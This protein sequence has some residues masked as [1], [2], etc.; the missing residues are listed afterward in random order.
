MPLYSQSIKNF[1]SGISQQA[2]IQR[3][4]EQ[5]EVQSNGLSTESAGLQKRPPTIFISRLMDA[6]PDNVQPL[7]HFIDRDANEKYIVY[8]FNNTIRIFDFEGNEKAVNMQ[9]DADYISTDNPKDELRLVTIADY[10]FIVNTN[11][12]VTMSTTKSPDSFSTQGALINVK[13]GQYGRTYKIW[14]DGQEVASHTTPD[15]SDK[16]H[17]AMIDTH[18]IAEQLAARAREAGKTVD[19]G[20]CWLRIKPATTVATQDGFN[21][22]AMIGVTDTVQRFSLLPATAPADYTI[23]VKTDPNGD[24]AGSYYVKYNDEEKVWEECVCPNILIGLDATTMPHALEREADGSFTFKR[25]S[26]TE[27]KVGDEDSN[28]LPSFVDYTI[29][30]IFFYRNRLGLLSGEN[31]ILSE[32]GEYFNFWMTTATDILDIDPIDV[33][34]TTTR[35]N[36]LNY[37]IPFDGE[38]Y[39]FSDKSQFVLRADTTLSP[40]NVA[41]VEVTGFQ[42]SPGCRPIVAGRNLYFP[43]ERSEFTS[44]KEYYS[45]LDTSEMKNAQ[46]ITAHVP[47]YIPN[48]VHEIVGANNENIMLVLTKGEP[49]YIYVYKYLFMN[50]QRVQASWSLWNMYNRVISVYFIGSTVYLLLNRGNSHVLEKMNFTVSKTVDFVDKEIYR[51]YLDC[52]KVATTATYDDISETTSINIKDEYNLNDNDITHIGIVLPEGIYKEFS[53]IEDNIIKVDGNY[54]GTNIILGVPYRF[55]IKLSPIYLRSTDSNGGQKALTNGRLQLRYIHFTYADTGGFVVYVTN[56]KDLNKKTRT[57]SMTARN[58]GTLS[59]RLG[60]ILEQTGEFKVPLQML[61]T[62]CDIYIES[63]LPLPLALI[64]YSFDATWVQRSKG[65]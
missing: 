32:S 64:D 58:V 14:I 46:D 4:A 48:G 15:G 29:S 55:Y 26:W 23:L 7:V 12:K 54:E 40:R 65:V 35:I 24:E 6:I 37:A 9:N 18:Y 43:A 49:N 47:N 60:A 39:C 27:R 41:L 44:I 2:P 33:A 53:D 61:N 25:L 5:L 11:K 21:N 34:T 13:Q 1:V 22:N 30:D 57:Y 62:S 38:L 42:S 50:E 52:K 36:F 19:L 3:Y 17:T 63:S 51:V 56:N 45:V 31:V 59:A 16:S 10:T 20:D 8:V 28:P